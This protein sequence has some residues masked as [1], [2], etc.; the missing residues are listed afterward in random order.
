MIS[1]IPPKKDTE[2][3]IFDLLK[4]VLRRKYLFIISLIFGLLLGYLFM[5]VS[6][7]EY[8]SRLNYSID[9]APPFYSE[10]KIFS[11]FD[12]YFFSNT[13]FDLWKKDNQRTSINFDLF[14]NKKIIEGF[15]LSK[16]IDENLVLVNMSQIIIKT[17]SLDI[18]DDF[19]SYVN[20]VNFLLKQKYIDR[21]NDELQIIKTRLYESTKS[22]NILKN[23]LEIDRLLADVEK[24][25]QIFYIKRPTYPEEVSANIFQVIVIS[26]VLGGVIGLIIIFL[27][28]VMNRYK[29]HF[30]K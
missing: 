10:K 9:T 6:G 8:H 17:K 28:E 22:E 2:I 26:S 25:S 23:I 14:S 24:G 16:E 5:L 7:T 1:E 13:N 4:I 29:K 20:F 30:N 18:L 21:A 15:E 19:Y 11:D 12:Q 27:L 3:E